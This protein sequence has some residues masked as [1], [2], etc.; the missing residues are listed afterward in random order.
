MGKNEGQG[1]EAHSG[2]SKSAQ[3][4]GKHHGLTS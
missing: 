3:G 1:E 4:L 2:H